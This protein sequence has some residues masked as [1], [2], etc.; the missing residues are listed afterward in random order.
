MSNCLVSCLLNACKRPV[1]SD[2][3]LASTPYRNQSMKKAR[4]K[5]RHV[6][7]RRKDNFSQNAHCNERNSLTRPVFHELFENVHSI[8][9]EVFATIKNPAAIDMLHAF[10]VQRLRFCGPSVYFI[11]TKFHSFQSYFSCNAIEL[12]VFAT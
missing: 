7:R 6:Y 8:S 5:Q 2:V 3:K 11:L 10:M 9:N 12:G 4:T 1:Q